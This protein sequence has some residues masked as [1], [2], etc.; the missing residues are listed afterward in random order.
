MPDVPDAGSAHSQPE[1]K[2]QSQHAGHVECTRHVVQMR[3]PCESSTMLVDREHLK[4][5][6]SFCVHGQ[7]MLEQYSTIR[8]LSARRR[9]GQLWRCST[10][11]ERGPQRRLNNEPTVTHVCALRKSRH[12]T[13]GYPSVQPVCLQYVIGMRLQAWGM[14]GYNGRPGTAN[15]LSSSPVL[16]R[17][18][19]RTTDAMWVWLLTELPT[20]FLLEALCV[21]NSV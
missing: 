16:L 15:R 1:R 2:T 5:S 17:L 11:R 13:A 21:V 6:G 10:G 14:T 8:D 12:I 18:G 19:T 20:K 7:H 4:L 9:R 3:R